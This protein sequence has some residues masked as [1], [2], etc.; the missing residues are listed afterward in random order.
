MFE[1]P[2]GL[3]QLQ[4]HQGYWEEINFDLQ[5]GLRGSRLGRVGIRAP[6]GDHSGHLL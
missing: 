2:S 3:R 5:V 6:A 1:M 4:Q